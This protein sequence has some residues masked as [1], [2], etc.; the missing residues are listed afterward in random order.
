MGRT[1]A[2]SV[3]ERL[4]AGGLAEDT[5]VAVVENAGR[6]DSR[7]LHGTLKELPGLEARTE[8]TGP[9]MVIIGDAV[10]GGVV[11]AK[12][13]LSGVVAALGGHSEPAGGFGGVVEREWRRLFTA[14]GRHEGFRCFS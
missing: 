6:R 10:A 1:V 12:F 7:L 13:E 4:M 8:L 3:A 14:A 2:A 9:V 11:V 5:T